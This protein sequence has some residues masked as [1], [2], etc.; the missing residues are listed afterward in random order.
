[1]ISRLSVKQSIQ[2]V[3]RARCPLRSAY[4]CRKPTVG[5]RRLIAKSV[6]LVQ[7]GSMSTL[8]SIRIEGGLLGLDVL[9]QLLTGDLPGQ[10]AADFG[11]DARRSLTDEIAAAFADA[12]ALWGVFQHRLQK[13]SEEDIATSAPAMPG[14]S[15]FLG[16][17]AMSPDTIHA[18][19]MW[20]D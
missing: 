16:S 19:T 8:N 6:T 13:L 10:A 2:A 5:N 12:R 20:T 15:H 1:M 4:A 7:T 18:P 9:D 11:L 17:W 3:I 14:Q